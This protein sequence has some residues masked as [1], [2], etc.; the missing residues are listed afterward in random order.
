MM[1]C[2][3]AVLRATTIHKKC[4]FLFPSANL[5][6]LKERHCDLSI[7]ASFWNSNVFLQTLPQCHCDEGMKQSFNFTKPCCPRQ[8]RVSSQKTFVSTSAKSH[9]KQAHSVF[10]VTSICGIPNGDV[11]NNTLSEQLT[12]YSAA[13]LRKGKFFSRN[14]VLL[15]PKTL[16]GIADSIYERALASTKPKRTFVSHVSE[17]LTL[18]WMRFSHF[19]DTNHALMRWMRFA[20]FKVT[21]LNLA[22]L[23]NLLVS[24]WPFLQL[25]SHLSPHINSFD[26]FLTTPW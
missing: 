23:V 2:E 8:Q 25:S 14:R 1:V 21:I 17:T 3:F 15:V 11:N 19:W 13:I 6:H 22:F 18:R 12:V 10:V 9:P 16:S 20:I 5:L 4:G 26:F 7:A 24:V